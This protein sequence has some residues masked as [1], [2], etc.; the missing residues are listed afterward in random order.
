MAFGFHPRGLGAFIRQ[1]EIALHAVGADTIGCSSP[2]LR[3]AKRRTLVKALSNSLWLDIR[4]VAPAAVVQ[5]TAARAFQE[6]CLRP[7]GP[8]RNRY[9]GVAS[10]EQDD[11][12]DKDKL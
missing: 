10:A 11:F 4:M 2:A 12:I 3:R 6:R 8:R 9:R 1:L 7:L 5:G